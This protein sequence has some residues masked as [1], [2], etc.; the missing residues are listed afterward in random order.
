MT[1]A[2][3]FPPPTPGAPR[4]GSRSDASRRAVRR[5]RRIRHDAPDSID[6]HHATRYGETDHRIAVRQP[7]YRAHDGTRDR[8]RW[9][10]LPHEP[11][12]HRP[13][14]ERVFDSSRRRRN[15]ASAIVQ[16]EQ[17]PVLE[18]LH[19]VLA[20]ESA[21]RVV[22]DGEVAPVAA[23]PPPRTTGLCVDVHDFVN[24]LQGDD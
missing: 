5:E 21:E 11:R 10:E 2:A 1:T 6:F 18:H 17:V 8:G 16:K 15:G 13:R 14:V 22:E 19:A 23:E 7:L 12:G 9:P 20:P 24:G 3:A 4:G